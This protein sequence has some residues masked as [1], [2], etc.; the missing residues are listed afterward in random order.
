MITPLNLTAI[1]AMDRNR[2][3]GHQGKLPWHYPED[4]QFFKRM[5]LKHP[6]I[7]GRSTFESIG[8]PLP[9]RQNIVISRTMTVQHGITIA[10]GPTDAFAFLFVE[11]PAFIIGG[12]KIYEQLLPYCSE[13]LITEVAGVHEGDT[14]MPPFEEQFALVEDLTPLRHELEDASLRFLRYRRRPSHPLPRTLSE[15]KFEQ[16]Y[17]C[18]PQRKSVP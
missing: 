13:L 12:A 8:R 10:R 9:G 14:F 16:E 11:E 2:V 5:T 18:E 4:L 7:M 3:I 1:A 6:V 15:D 17:M